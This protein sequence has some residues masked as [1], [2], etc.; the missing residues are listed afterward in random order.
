MTHR[1]RL[2]YIEFLESRDMGFEGQLGRGNPFCFLK[3]WSGPHSLRLMISLDQQTG[4][5]G[6]FLTN[7]CVSGSLGYFPIDHGVV[8]RIF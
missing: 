4:P 5:G 8:D 6:V 1:L 3:G 2:P 7:E